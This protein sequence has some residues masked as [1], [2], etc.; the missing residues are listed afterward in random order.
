MLN[1]SFQKRVTVYHD[2]DVLSDYAVNIKHQ[3]DSVS[4]NDAVPWMK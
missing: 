1:L 4:Y 3:I 2:F